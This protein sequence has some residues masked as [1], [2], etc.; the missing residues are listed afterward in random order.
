MSTIA[1]WHVDPA[2]ETEMAA[3]HGPIWRRM[4]ELVEERDL[5]GR[6]VLDYGCNQGGFLRLLHALRPFARGLGLDIATASVARAEALKGDLP[7]QYAVLGD[8]APWTG[9]FD[10][11]FSH[12]VVYLVP[13][14]DAH[15][16]DIARLLRPGGVYYAVTG[17]HTDSPLWPR[18]RELIPRISNLPVQDRSIGDYAEAFRGAGL[19]VSVRRLGF[20]GY[21]PARAASE[22]YPSLADQLDYLANTKMVFRIVRPPTP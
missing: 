16:A 6:T 14:L 9:A 17:C 13:D 8:L 19:A 10:L 12:E 2:A 11:A 1:T 4:I 22:W 20:D 18:W 3:G 7:L 15:A 21:V 5:T